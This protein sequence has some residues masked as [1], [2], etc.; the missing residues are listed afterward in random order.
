MGQIVHG[1]DAL[2]R[3]DERGH[4]GKTSAPI[5]KPADFNILAMK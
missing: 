3:N 2:Q 1:N 4:L 5:K